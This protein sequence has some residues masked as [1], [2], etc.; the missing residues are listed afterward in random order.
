MSGFQI[1]REERGEWELISDPKESL[2]FF[3]QEKGNIEQYVAHIVFSYE[4][5]KAKQHKCK[6]EGNCL[7]ILLI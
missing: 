7:G 3:V 2:T 5:R 1:S 4:Q 6:S